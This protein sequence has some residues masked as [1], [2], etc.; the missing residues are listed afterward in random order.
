M[1]EASPTRRD[2]NNGPGKVLVAARRI[3]RIIISPVT[4]WLALAAGVINAREFRKDVMQQMRL[5]VTN[6]HPE[7]A[8][9]A[10]DR[11][12]WYTEIHLNFG[13]FRLRITRAIYNPRLRDLWAD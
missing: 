1:P 2:V 9:G 10:T 3:V 12:G 4:K 8:I 5:T 11:R 13:E 7:I 6:L